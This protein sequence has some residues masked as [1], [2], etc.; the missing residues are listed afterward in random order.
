MKIYEITWIDSVGNDGWVLRDSV[1]EQDL[2]TITTVGYILYEDKERINLTMS[3]TTHDEVGAYIVIP[4][5]AIKGKRLL[6]VNP[7]K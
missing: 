1:I 2:G 5:F 4:K 3:N 6:S 7:K